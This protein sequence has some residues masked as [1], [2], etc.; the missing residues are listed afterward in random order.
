MCGRRIAAAFEAKYDTS[1][2]I[3]L[4]SHLKGGCKRLAVAWVELP[5]QLE[6]PEHKIELPKE[7]EEVGRTPDA[8]DDANEEEDDEQVSSV[9][10]RA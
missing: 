10:Y 2:K 7:L 5:D 3:E 6:Q 8:V 1:L 9:E 4:S